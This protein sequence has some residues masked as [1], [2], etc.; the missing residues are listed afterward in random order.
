M[1]PL[2]TPLLRYA[3]PAALL[4]AVLALA[5]C[6]KK[7]GTPDAAYV[8]PEGQLSANARLIVYPDMPIEAEVWFDKNADGG[9]QDLPNDVPGLGDTL[10][11]T[12]TVR[13]SPG[14]NYGLI[15]D[16]TEAN[17]FQVLRRAS[18][19]GFELLKDYTLQPVDRFLDSHWDL[20]RFSDTRPSGFSPATYLGR[21]LLGGQVTAFS[22]LTN[23]GVL[24]ATTVEDLVY[25]GASAP[26]DSNITMRWTQVDGAA[27]YWMQV[28]QVTGGSVWQLAQPAPLLPAISRNS[29]L[30]FVPAPAD[31]Y[32]VGVRQPGD[33]VL[34]RRPLLTNIEYYVRISAVDE[35]GRM[36]AFTYGNYRIVPKVTGEY[37]R[38]RIG[39]A[40]VKPK[41]PGTP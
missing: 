11:G 19:G 36:L 18:N 39:A 3:A 15:V 40:R 31:T 23:E 4:L 30:G 37:Y 26:T 38:L 27:G 25:T 14:S 32:K 8:R 13:L 22:P 34:T 35:R 12:E 41:R 24:G 21:G 6:S 7:L 1:I 20:Y 16:G 29:F 2:R 10:L 9:V 33:L 17:S 28:F 5:G